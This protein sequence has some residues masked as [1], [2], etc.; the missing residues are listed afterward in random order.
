MKSKHKDTP[1][2]SVIMPVYNSEAYL[3]EAIESILGQSY[4]H[5]EFIIIDD[6]STDGSRIVIESYA[7]QDK[8]I[9]PL[10]LSHRGAGGA[11]NAGITA[12]KGELIARMDADDIALPERF[13]TQISWMQR[14]GVD[15]CGSCI[16]TFGAEK[17]IMWFPEC[18]EAVQVEM[19][20]RCALMQPTIMLRTDIAKMHPY[21]ENLFFEDYELWTRLAIKYRTGN[22]QQVL[23]KYRTHSQ[24]RHLINA[25]HVRNE[26]QNYCKAY[27]RSLFPNA[28]KNDESI[29]AQIVCNEP[30]ESLVE[31]ERAGELLTRFASIN[32]NLLRNRLVHRWTSICRLSTFLGLGAY[33]CY[34]NK[35]CK[36]GIR[37]EKP[38]VLWLAF[39]CLLHLKPDSWAEIQIKNLLKLIR[40]CHER[41]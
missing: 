40:N 2:I 24:Q 8:R 39:A 20:F 37:P 17:R 31:L 27:F 36:F 33:R 29:I 6:C 22:V 11:A 1:L 16:K 9:H 30:F 21:K 10:Y 3:S 15:I 35:I 13:A 34:R 25:T 14:T 32:D 5:F 41:K 38:I 18:H 7:Q 23:L 12:A 28:P 19:L 26:L 4:T